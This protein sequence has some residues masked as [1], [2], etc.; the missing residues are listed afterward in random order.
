MAGPI[1]FNKAFY[2]FSYQLDNTKL[3]QQARIPY[4]TLFIALVLAF[5]VG[6]CTAYWAHL[7]AYYAQGSN[8]IPSA[9]EIGEY[10]EKQARQDFELMASQIEMLKEI[11]AGMQAVVKGVGENNLAIQENTEQTRALLAKVDSYFGTTSGLDYD[12]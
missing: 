8:L 9:G 10:R 2:N 4:R 12:N 6:L 3:S 11:S 5:V 7:S 1:R